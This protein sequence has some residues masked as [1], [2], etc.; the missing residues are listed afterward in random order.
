MKVT[1][2]SHRVLLYTVAWLSLTL[3]LISDSHFVHIAV[4][5]CLHSTYANLI[6]RRGD[7]KWKCRVSGWEIYWAMSKINLTK[8]LHYAII[9]VSLKIFTVEN[10]PLYGS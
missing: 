8:F 3:Q 10:F 5:I 6:S 2:E 9:W 1:D 4:D 7:C